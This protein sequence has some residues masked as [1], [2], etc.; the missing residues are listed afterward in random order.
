MDL[1]GRVALVT[2]AARRVG[3]S[4]ALRL[5]ESGCDVAIHYRSS[6]DEASA[7]A[8]ECRAFGARAE[9]LHADLADTASAPA[10][11]SDVHRTF[12]QLDVLI[13]NA[14]VFNSMTLEEFSVEK[15]EQTLRVNLT[16]PM[17]LAHA[18]APLLREAGGEI[19]NLCDVST[20][21]PWPSHLAYAVSKGGLDTLTKVLARA[22]APEVRVAGVAVGVAAWPPAYNQE[23]RERVLRRT[24][25]GRAGTPG[26]VAAMVRYLLTEGDYI[27]G[28][29]LALDGGR[30]IA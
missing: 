3:R 22:L 24:P 26:D 6:A 23:R 13:N 12:G 14:A 10:L 29:I 7:T 21:R 18:A 17:A 20:A 15:W 28:A 16:A 5:A 11:V 1:R 2:G 19:I 4:I 27:T 25:L 8:D 9:T 30:S